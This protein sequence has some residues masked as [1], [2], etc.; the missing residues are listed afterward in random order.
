MISAFL[1]SIILTV[2]PTQG[3]FL[4][5]LQPRDSILIADQLEYGFELK[6]VL[7]GTKLLL[8]QMK[9]EDEDSEFMILSDWKVDT[10]KAYRQKKN[11]QKKYDLKAGFVVTTF[12]EGEYE[13]PGLMAVVETPA[14]QVDTLSFESLK[15]TVTTL[16]IDGETFEIHDIKGQIRYPVT[17]K[18]ILPYLAGF[19]LFATLAILVVCLILMRRKRAQGILVHK[20]PAHIVALRKLDGFRGDKLW[21]PEKQKIFYSGVTDAL[22]E[23]IVNRYGVSAME[24]TTSEIFDDLKGAEIPVDLY[25]EMEELFRRSDFVKF[26]KYVATREENAEVLPI[27]V[28]FVTTT[29]QSEVDSESENLDAAAEA[30]NEE[31]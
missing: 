7:E 29:Y 23:Y 14:G 8:P 27:A 31:E 19:W 4:T 11:Q 10:L 16:P 28:R 5:P 18:E 20:D 17:F 26:A 22:R 15:M 6:E 12:Q 25:K 2:I 30:E 21:V 3:A 9:V 1:L 13:L 24:M